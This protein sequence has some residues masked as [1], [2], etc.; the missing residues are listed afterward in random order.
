MGN[1][2]ARH[3]TFSSIEKVVVRM[4][5]DDGSKVLTRYLAIMRS[6]QTLV[7]VIVRVD[8]SLGTDSSGRAQS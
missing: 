1:S 5:G 7:V 3:R 8:V 4:N 2:P 6:Q